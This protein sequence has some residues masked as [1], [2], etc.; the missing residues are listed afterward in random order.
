MN[1]N[2]INIKILFKI[3]GFV[4]LKT[5]KIRDFNIWLKI[6]YYGN[7]MKK[8]IIDVEIFKALS[9]ETRLNILRKLH[10][11]RMNVTEL[12]SSVGIKKS[13]LLSHL[14]KLQEN[15]LVNRYKRDGRKWVYYELTDK[16]LHLV[17]PKDKKYLIIVSL[18]IITFFS[19]LASLIHFFIGFINSE[20]YFDKPHLIIIPD[21]T[22]NGSIPPLIG[23]EPPSIF[24]PNELSLYV[25]II[26]FVLCTILTYYIIRKYMINKIQD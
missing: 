5:N 17:D 7:E 4:S 15:G 11:N 22:T 19:G 10:N 21:N 1:H 20:S 12:S 8:F 16:G 2:N 6:T 18:T 3:N 9:S 13:T 23:K 24:G 25:S 26:L 14:E